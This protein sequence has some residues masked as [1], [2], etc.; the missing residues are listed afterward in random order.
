METVSTERLLALCELMIENNIRW[1]NRYCPNWENIPD[2]E[3]TIYP[4][5]V[6]S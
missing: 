6:F 2:L 4:H 1:L 5:E 3:I